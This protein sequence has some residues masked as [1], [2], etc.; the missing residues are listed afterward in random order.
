MIFFLITKGDLIIQSYSEN[1]IKE[2]RFLSLLSLATTRFFMKRHLLIGLA[3]LFAGQVIFAQGFEKAYKPEYYAWF[4]CITSDGS[5]GWIAGGYFDDQASFFKTAWVTRI[6]P[7]GNIVWNFNATSWEYGEVKA[8]TP[9]SGNNYVVAGP[10]SG[11]DWGPGG[12]FINMVSP[13]GT[14]VWTRE[15]QWGQFFWIDFANI[16]ELRN[17]GF[18]LSADSILLKTNASGDST[19]AATLGYGRI[20]AIVENHRHEYIAGCDSGIARTDSSGNVLGYIPFAA[21]VKQLQQLPDSTYVLLTGT[22]LVRTDTA[23]TVISSVSLSS[24]FSNVRTLE[25]GT[26]ICVAG[27]SPAGTRICTFDLQLQPMDTATFGMAEPRDISMFPSGYAVAG[28]EHTGLNNNAF[29]K[30][31]DNGLLT[32]SHNTD[33]GVVS[34]RVDNLYA[35]PTQFAPPGVYDIA[36]ETFVTVK[37]FGS[38]TLNSLF[39]NSRLFTF[40]PCWVNHYLG[41]FNIT[42]APGDSVEVAMGYLYDYSLYNPGPVLSY[43]A[44]FWT[45]APNGKIDS[46]HANDSACF[47]FQM[48]VGIEEQHDEDFSVYPN[49][50]SSVLTCKT[51]AASGDAVLYQ[52]LDLHGRMLDSGTLLHDLAGIDLSGL[53]PGI[54]FVKLTSGSRSSAHKVVKMQ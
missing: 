14:S 21:P 27:T 5:N 25:A 30:T 46:D 26:T 19:W 43:S 41:S 39:L 7:S 15:Y 31:F 48:P 44:C 16:I 54:Y 32:P 9:T 4:N 28:I 29:V 33:A 45:S 18:L 51:G 17:S 6:D 2:G 35:Q 8:I 38:D 20:N 24:F 11:C 3:L 42:I 13:N 1:L 22:D 34:W 47:S 50:A 23:F 53:Q 10:M 52:V 12:G 36:F 49:P 37:N 40:Y